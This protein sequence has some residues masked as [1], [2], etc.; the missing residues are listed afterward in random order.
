[1]TSA[2]IDYAVKS[3]WWSDYCYQNKGELSLNQS[4]FDF[5]VK[6]VA[7]NNSKNNGRRRKIHQIFMMNCLFS[8]CLYS[9]K[10]YTLWQWL[11]LQLIYWKKTMQLTVLLKR[12]LL[13]LILQRNAFV[14]KLYGEFFLQITKMF[15]VRVCSHESRSVSFPW[16]MT[17]LEEEL[18]SVH[19]MICWPRATLSRMYKIS[20]KVELS[21]NSHI[22][23]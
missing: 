8:L 7:K 16:S 18:P 12:S 22:V 2:V 6:R 10:Q 14:T 11:K 5:F 1:M 21:M 13:Q 15:G 19:V 20:L 4:N 3:S 23:Y 17:V 9:G